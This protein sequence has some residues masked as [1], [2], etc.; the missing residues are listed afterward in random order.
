[1]NS[2]PCIIILTY[3]VAQFAMY[4]L[5]SVNKWR[6]Y[7]DDL[8]S[9]KIDF[10]SC[11]LNTDVISVSILKAF[12][13][14]VAWPPS[15]PA[16]VVILVVD[17]VP[18]YFIQCFITKMGMIKSVHICINVRKYSNKFPNIYKGR[19]PPRYFWYQIRMLSDQVTIVI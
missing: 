10:L 2:L 12:W 1:M 19:K 11:T 15:G 7:F 17:Y 9:F 14:M 6:F 5:M 4:V 16:T 3:N 8:L 13:L 18:K